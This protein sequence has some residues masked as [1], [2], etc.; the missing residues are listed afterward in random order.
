MAHMHLLQIFTQLRIKSTIK[1][2]KPILEPIN[3]MVHEEVVI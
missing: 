3:L 1:F 2:V